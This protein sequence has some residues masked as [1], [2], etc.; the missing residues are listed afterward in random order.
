M[1]C[2][3][4]P[5]VH[6]VLQLLDVLRASI[7]VANPWYRRTWKRGQDFKK[8]NW[9]DEGRDRLCWMQVHSY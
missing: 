5:L 2:E 6:A 4:G 7:W 9:V 8:V 1:R 3:H